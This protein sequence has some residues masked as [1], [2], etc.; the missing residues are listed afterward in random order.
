MNSG[1]T[2]QASDTSYDALFVASSCSNLTV[3]D[4][5]TVGITSTQ[6]T[7]VGGDQ[8]VR[9][10][11]SANQ[12]SSNKQSIITLT[13]TGNDGFTYSDTFTLIQSGFVP[14]ESSL[15][16][17]DKI[18]ILSPTEVSAYY[19]IRTTNIS[20]VTVSFS[21]NVNITNHTLTAT[22]NG[23]ELFVF[24]ADNTSTAMLE[25]T[26]TATG[27]T[28]QGITLTDTATLRKKGVAGS[29]SL[30]PNNVSVS[31]SAGN[32]SSVVT[33]AGIVTALTV[34]YWGSGGV[35]TVTNASISGSTL[36]VAYGANST[37][38]TVT[39]YVRVR[40]TDSYGD[41]QSATLVIT[42]AG[43]SPSASITITPSTQ[44]VRS[45]EVYAAFNITTSGTVNNL[46]MT[47]TDF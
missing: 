9:I 12:D 46:M 4:S 14:A 2:V 24:T 31:S 5:G 20:S 1:A 44:T 40:G 32:T 8:V 27:T 19:F 18:R 30:N 22:E 23:Y 3:S 6:I 26:I 34:D 21:G 11:F 33:A 35:T 28:L 29:I 37:A 7:T 43:A 41:V 39:N 47:T 38:N 42:Q 13:G 10:S 45:N 36:T 16:F 15:E 25:T 17:G